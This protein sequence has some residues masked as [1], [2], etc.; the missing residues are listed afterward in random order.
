MS[1]PTHCL[2]LEC[3]QA[4]ALI[5]GALDHANLWLPPRPELLGTRIAV[6]AVPESTHGTDFW[7]WLLRGKLGLAMPPAASMT[8]GILGTLRLVGWA[9]MHYPYRKIVKQEP[10]K[11]IPEFDGPFTFGPGPFVWVF[12][13]PKLG[14]HTHQMKTLRAG[15]ADQPSVRARDTQ[16]VVP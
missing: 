2:P 15:Y 3:C 14:K 16:P 10:A 4:H 8:P 9:R 13:K 1:P 11:G 12:E 6:Q 7:Y 5:S